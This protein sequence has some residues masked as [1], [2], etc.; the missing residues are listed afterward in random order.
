MISKEQFLELKHLKSLGVPTTTICKKNTFFRNGFFLF[1]AASSRLD[2]L[3]EGEGCAN[4]VCAVVVG[5][6]MGNITQLFQV[7]L[8]NGNKTHKINTASQFEAQ[9]Y[10]V[11]KNRAGEYRKNLSGGAEYKSFV[12]AP[13][14][15]NPTIDLGSDMLKALIKANNSVSAR[16]GMPLLPLWKRQSHYSK[17]RRSY[18]IIWN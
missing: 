2:K 15:H 17:T 9:V 5:R 11:M 4:M 14:P 7:K 18:L 1:S 3:T 16:E 12:P 6:S 8:I 10:A 13:L